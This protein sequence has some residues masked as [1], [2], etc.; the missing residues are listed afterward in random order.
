MDLMSGDEDTSG[1]PAPG[2]VSSTVLESQ[3]QLRDRWNIL[4]IGNVSCPFG[5]PT[6]LGFGKGGIF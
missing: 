6:C 4:M 2:G 5:L 1:L 3:T